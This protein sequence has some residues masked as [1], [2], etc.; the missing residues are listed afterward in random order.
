MTMENVN[1]ANGSVGLAGSVNSADLT[2]LTGSL[3][4]GA[5]PN[6]SREHT[7]LPAP[8]SEQM[9]DAEAIHALTGLLS[10]LRQDV[11]RAMSAELPAQPQNQA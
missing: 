3:E 6:L 2:S 11:D 9:S 8:L 1:G 5:E 10:Q 4:P 7:R